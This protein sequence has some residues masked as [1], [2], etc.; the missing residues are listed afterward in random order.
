MR[1]N[2]LRGNMNYLKIISLLGVLFMWSCGNK[3]TQFSLPSTSQSFDQVIT[4]NN[5]VDLLFVVDNSKSMGQ[6]QVKLSTQVPNLISTLN[7]LKMDYHVAVTTTTMTT[8]ALKYPMTRQLIGS[9]KYLTNQNIQ[10]LSKR[11][12][13]GESG[14][15]NERGLD[16]LAYVT[17]DYAQIEASGF[18]RSSA[19]FVVIFLADEN[20][21]SS[22]FGKSNSSDFVDLMNK[23]KPAFSDGNRAWIANY[24]GNISSV[25]CDILGG[26]TSIGTSYLKLVEASH[27]IKESICS[28]DLSVAV[29]N[30]KARFIDQ[31]T[32]FRLKDVP[33]KDSIYIEVGG[34]A[35]IEDSVNGW[36]LETEID[37]TGVTGYYIKFHGSAIPAAD[38]SINV[39]YTPAA[40]S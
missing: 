29:S 40:A 25:G 12:L 34:V 22:E 6:Y 17:G 20:D 14:S 27:G 7:N 15:D 33:N 32:S 26:Y 10:L 19:L 35:V 16:A 30:I 39:K 8:D 24:I 5:K 31:L 1:R 38:Q 13:V 28:A 18:L 21:N 36:T 37:E 23:L 9:P 2:S 4:Y 11:L 3:A